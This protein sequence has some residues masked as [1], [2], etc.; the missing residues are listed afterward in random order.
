MN[1][2][3]LCAA[4]ALM[5][6]AL[7]SCHI[8]KKY[9][10]P[11]ND[12]QIVGDFKKAVD[13]PVDS[14][15]LPYLGWEKI[16]QDPKLQ[17]LIHLALANNKDLKNAKLNVDIAR[18]QLKGAKL[19]YFPAVAISPNGG[20]ATYGGNKMD[21]T[22]MNWSYTIPLSVSWEIDAFVKILNRKRGAQVS[23]EM[24]KDYEQA[25]HSQIVCGVASAYYS[26]VMLNQQLDLTKRTCDIWAE[27]VTSMELL[28]EAGRTTEAAVVQSRANLYNIQSSIPTLEHSI[29]S[30]QNTI[31]LLLNTYPQTWDVTNTL[32][33]SIP[34]QL[35]NGIPVSYLAVRPDVR[36]A[37]KSMAVA[38]YSTNSARAAFYPS[39]VISA[40]GGFTNLLGSMIKNPGEWFFQ[41]AGQL[42]A[43]IFSRGQN[44]ASLEA[45][46]AQQKQ[47]L[48]NF[49]Y[50]VLSASADVSNALVSYN[51]NV[52]KNKFLQLQVDE[53]EKSVEYTN[54]LFMYNQ[55]TTYLEVLT[56]RS[57][58]LNAQLACIANWHERAAALISL[59]QSVGGGR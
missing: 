38:Y 6:V 57:S 25:V 24:S 5:A 47:A 50:A 26:L 9:E 3:K 18:A 20:T 35:I 55:S 29:H 40:Q 30:V 21:W 59:Y 10:L 44:I 32:D 8:Y 53:L 28:K 36:A 58:L 2:I 54:E 39:I 43:P 13:T 49:E 15:A 31:S 41:L 1:N 52:E 12:S 4:G 37:E 45:A 56:A 33:F 14:T 19:S 34:D 16:F 48:N 7:S 46:K 17:N 51:K 11:V 22:D 42:T 23:M 27:Q